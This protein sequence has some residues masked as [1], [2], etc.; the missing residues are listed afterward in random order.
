MAGTLDLVIDG[1]EPLSIVYEDEDGNPIDLT[2]YNARM[3]VRA[4]Y[5]PD[6]YLYITFGTARPFSG[7][8]IP[9]PLTGEL[10][11]SEV[12]LNR[13]TLIAAGLPVGKLLVWDIVVYTSTAIRRLL[14]GTFLLPKVVTSVG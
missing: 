11:V 5:L 7:I 2:G 4:S 1:A 6:G 8:T 3:Q 14:T 10:I 9:D 12:A 13:E